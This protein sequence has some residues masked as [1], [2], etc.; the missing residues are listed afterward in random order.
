MER[1]HHTLFPDGFRHE[2]QKTV[3][4]RDIYLWAAL[5]GDR[6][7]VSRVSAFAQQATIVHHI[8]PDAYLTSLV[9]VSA[10]GLAARLPPPGAIMTT[11]RMHFAAPVL[12]GTTLSVV[13]TVATWDSVTGLY[14]LD[15]RMTGA[16]GALAM[17]GAAGLRPRTSL[18]AAV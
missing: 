1:T 8:A 10:A 4:A 5:I 15:I 17:V 14:W 12:V 16:D 18:L 2:V 11:L 9:V 6:A 13:V 3:T 7:P